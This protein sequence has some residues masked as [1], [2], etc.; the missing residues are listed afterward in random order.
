MRENVT[1]EAFLPY[2]LRLLYIYGLD[3]SQKPYPVIYHVGTEQYSALSTNVLRYKEDWPP[4]TTIAGGLV[5][6]SVS[7]GREGRP[8]DKEN[9]QVLHIF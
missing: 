3:N 6:Y 5:F 4:H 7:N 8:V 1:Y 2:W 9:D